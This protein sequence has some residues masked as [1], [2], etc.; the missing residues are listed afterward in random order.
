M[1]NCGQWE[2]IADG[3]LKHSPG[4]TATS[5]G[6][7]VVTAGW[8]EDGRSA[9]SY[10]LKDGQWTELGSIPRG[11]VGPCQVEVDN[12]IVLIGEEVNNKIY[13]HCIA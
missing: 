3:P 7:V 5:T 1:T 11:V 13:V 12:K 10:M 8:G 2:R 4:I 9:S 6:E